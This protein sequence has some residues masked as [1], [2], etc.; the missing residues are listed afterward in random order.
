MNRILFTFVYFLLN[1]DFHKNWTDATI[2]NNVDCID[3][4]IRGDV[5]LLTVNFITQFSNFLFNG[6]QNFW[7]FALCLL[8]NKFLLVT[9][10][11][12]IFCS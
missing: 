11:K 9:A 5:A 8:Q 2:T 12:Q 1:Q 6:F 7:S 4:I 10:N 3:M